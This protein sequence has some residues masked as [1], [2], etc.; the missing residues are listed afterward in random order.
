E[1]CT[2]L[3]A[4]LGQE[5]FPRDLEE[6]CVRAR[7]QEDEV[8]ALAR[9]GALGCYIAERR[10]AMWQAPLIARAARERWLPALR[11]AV[12]PP[13][14][15]PQPTPAEVFA[16]DRTA[17]GLAPEGHVLIHLRPTLGHRRLHRATDLV[18]VPASRVVEVAGQTIVL[19]SPPTAR[20]V[21]FMTL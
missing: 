3:E 10:Q 16:L 11:E 8:L 7:L 4:A 19:Q 15:L 6:R 21:W 18:G 1:A 5:P 2:R 20:G 14:H 12:D 17:L 9:A 13:V